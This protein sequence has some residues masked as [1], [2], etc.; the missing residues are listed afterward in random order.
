MQN[1]INVHIFVAI[2]HAGMGRHYLSRLL[3]LSATSNSALDSQSDVVTIF[4]IQGA[5]LYVNE[6]VR[7]RADSAE[8]ISNC[9]LCE[10]V[11]L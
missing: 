3:L 8:Q 1:E 10:V 7:A 5:F 4:G 11:Q 6:P 9:S 2:V